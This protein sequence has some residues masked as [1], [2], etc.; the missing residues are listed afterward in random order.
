MVVAAPEIGMRRRTFGLLLAS[1]AA[2]ATAL[3]L[4]H[5][6]A[7]LPDFLG[8]AVPFRRALDLWSFT[9]GRPDWN[10]HLF[11][12]PSLTV[13][14]HHFIQWLG[15]L[16]GRASGDFRSPADWFVAYLGDPTAAVVP[17]LVLHAVADAAT[18]VATGLVAERLRRGAGLV[19]AAM[20]ALAPL[21]IETSRFIFIE[22]LMAALALWS[23]ERMLAWREHGG[24]WRLAGAVLLAGLAVG[25]K[26]QALA[27][28]VPLAWVLFERRGVRGLALW[29]ALVVAMLAVFLA[30]TPYALLDAPTFLRDLGYLRRLTATGYLGNSGAP[31]AG[32]LWRHLLRDAGPVA[33]GLLGASLWSVLAAPRRSG[34]AVAV[35]LHLLG[36]ALPVAVARVEAARYLV[37]IPPAVAA[38]A[39]AAALDLADRVELRWRRPALALLLAALVLPVAVTGLT[40]AAAG[41]RSTRIAARRWCEAHLTSR[42]LVMAEMYTAPLASF[43]A[44]AAVEGSDVFQAASPALRRRYLDRPWFHVVTV[45]LVVVGSSTSLIQPRTG[46]VAEVPIFADAGDANQTFYDARLFAEAAFVLT[47]SA[48]RGRFE[49]DPVRYA[50]ECR[51][52]S[53]LDST[54]V[55]VARF[56]AGHG[57]DGPTIVIYRLGEDA[58]AALAAAGPLPVLWWAERI[59][60]AY[61]RSAT[62]LL[63][64]SWRDGA[65]QDPDGAPAP[66]VRSLGVY[67][68]DRIRP[69]AD[70]MAF[71][72]AE[73]GRCGAA[74]SFAEVSLLMEPGDEAARLVREYCEPSLAAPPDSA[75][76]SIPVAST[77]SR[78][79]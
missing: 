25:A 71:D 43:D 59:P 7:D 78:T 20:V 4:W 72:L 11:H 38:L 73:L 17:A 65:L 24:A 10:P 70:G 46:P 57:L 47:S 52:Y 69:Y 77:G 32:Y 54:A 48:V 44:R 53:R 39:A 42:D 68:N 1:T 2:C 45:P 56:A 14:L 19:A 49:A 37:T 40:A 30:T 31:G 76:R 12:F 51:L 67:F 26:Y 8:E 6:T 3:R 63:G 5:V 28:V 66:W 60:T 15:Y 29:P 9:G 61:R 41:G 23:L 36:F 64:E 79:R 55:V 22:T 50:A 27:L 75:G 33:V 58:R 21:L 13:Y 16:A 18:V 74:R 62:R 34:A 35:W